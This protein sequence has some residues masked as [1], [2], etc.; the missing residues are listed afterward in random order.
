M[1]KVVPKAGR[2]ITHG[3]LELSVTGVT[4]QKSD[5][6]KLIGNILKTSR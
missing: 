4:K 2:A 6:D 1:S 3:A 5:I